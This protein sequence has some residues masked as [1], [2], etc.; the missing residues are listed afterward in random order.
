MEQMYVIKIGEISL[1][2]GNR[3]IFEKRLTNNI[4]R[5]LGDIHVVITGR[6]GRFYLHYEGDDQKEIE[7]IEYTLAHV[8][9]IVAFS[10]TVKVEK[11]ID[12]IKKACGDIADKLMAEGNH[13]TFK[14]KAMR[15][16]KSFPLSS[17]QL[18]CELGGVVLDKYPDLKVDLKHPDFSIT[19]ELR[20]KAYLYGPD[21]KGL[22]GLPTGCAGR[23]VLLLSGGIDSPVAGYMMAKR[24]LALEAIYFHTYPFT[25]D[26]SLNKV[27]HLAEILSQ[28]MPSIKLHVVNY[29]PVQ[30]HIS[31]KCHKNESTL[32]SRAA[33]MKI[34]HYVCKERDCNSLVT[35]ES[36]SQVASQTAESLRFT[37]SSTDYPIFRPLIGMDKEEITTI[38]KRIGTYDTS[39]LPYDD[40]CSMFAPEFPLTKPVFEKI[41][42]SYDF[43]KIDDLLPEAVRSI[44]TYTMSD[45][46][47]V[48]TKK[49]VLSDFA[50]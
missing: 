5:Q 9:G 13:K 1:K 31:E 43:L 4:H 35:G 24:G 34:S 14:I 10:K 25:S 32:L 38:A 49:K 16:D 17:Y 28:Y 22:C 42:E 20:D 37:G 47:T 3:R 18:D 45:G 40:C 44:E 23:G 12:D 30:T 11:N 8:F 19:C 6:S 15:A 41:K 36:L 2:G 26:K 7:K 27:I 33:M 48:E 39:I 29:T 46:V 21:T 50:L